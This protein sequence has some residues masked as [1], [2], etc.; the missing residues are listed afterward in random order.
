[1][2]SSASAA[3][4]PLQDKSDRIRAGLKRAR[5]EGKR[6]GRP[7]VIIAGD[8]VVRLRD[9]GHSWAEIARKLKAGAGTVRRAFWAAKDKTQPCQNPCREII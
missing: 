8:L 9:A 6:I 7:R 5:A 1:M 3:R 4:L 2:N